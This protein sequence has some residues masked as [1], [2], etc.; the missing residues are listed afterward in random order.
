[1]S[2]RFAVIAAL[3][4]LA[5]LTVFAAGADLKGDPVAGHTFAAS[6]CA[7]CHAVDDRKAPPTSKAGAPSFQSIA[8][9][10]TTTAAGLYVF[11]VSQHE[12]MPQF[13]INEDDRQNVIAYIMSLKRRGKV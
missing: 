10:K 12:S 3:G 13:M 4:V 5:P 6:H 7:E 1:M 8:D 11:L 2:N 9:A